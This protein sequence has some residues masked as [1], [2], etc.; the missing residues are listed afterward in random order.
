MK[1]DKKST[2]PRAWKIE[3]GLVRVL[4]DEEL[5]TC[6]HCGARFERDPLKTRPFCSPGC[7]IA[8]A[9]TKLNSAP[10]QSRTNDSTPK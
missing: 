3:D 1:W 5:T 7:A 2:P 10:D 8:A 6:Q 4:T 9:E